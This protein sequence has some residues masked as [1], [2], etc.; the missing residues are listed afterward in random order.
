M[1]KEHIIKKRKRLGDKEETSQFKGNEQWEVIDKDTPVDEIIKKVMGKKKGSNKEMSTEREI[2]GGD[3]V[4]EPPENTSQEKVKKPIPPPIDKEDLPQKT[5]SPIKKKFKGA[6]KKGEKR[7]PTGGKGPGK[8]GISLPGPE[9][10][11]FKISKTGIME[12]FLGSNAIGIL[13]VILDGKLPSTWNPFPSQKSLTEEQHMF[14]VKLRI[15]NYRWA[16]DLIA[17]ILPKEIGVFG[18]VDHK[19]STLKDRVE[20]ATKEPK[21]PEVMQLIEHRTIEGVTEYRAEESP[22]P[23]EDTED[24]E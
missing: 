20:R 7:N 1:G 24:D 21:S 14:L 11:E 23:D 10:Q 15:R 3:I 19:H 8:K 9:G 5:A 22:L 13:R 17:K 12:A 4:S 16:F 18:S 2:E 6:A